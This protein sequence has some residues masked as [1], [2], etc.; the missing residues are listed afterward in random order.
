MSGSGIA[1]YWT[2]DDVGLPRHY[3][4]RIQSIAID[5]TIPGDATPETASLLLKGFLSMKNPENGGDGTEYAGGVEFTLPKL[6]MGGSAAMR[7]NPKIPAFLVDVGLELSS[8]IVLGSTGLGIYGFRGLVG[9]RYVAT[10]NA[11]GVP[12]DGPWWQYYKAKVADTYREGIVTD[13]FE[14]TDGFSLGAGVSV[15]TVPDGGR[16]FSS[17]LFFLLSL[18]EVFLLQGQGQI[19]KE[20]I[21]LDTTTDPP[22]FALL[23]ISSTSIEAAFG[24]NY[25]V[26]DDGSNPGAIATVNAL[27]EMGFFW[28]NSSA[29]YINLGKDQPEDRRIQV[30]LLTLF[31]AYFYINQTILLIRVL[32]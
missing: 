17:K 29:W 32:L 1:F 5:I 10:K 3:F 24:V 28:G 7:L 2:T 8:P 13:K 11:A 15:A 20:R 19:L 21:G 25:K 4:V 30:R 9:Q 18:P 23:A 27:I 12:D 22:F 14:Q 16:T 26:P 6:K 31:N